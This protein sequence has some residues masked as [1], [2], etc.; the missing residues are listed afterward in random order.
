M[1]QPRR[2]DVL[3]KDAVWAATYGAAFTRQ[4]FDRL[5]EGRGAPNDDDFDRF[6]EEAASVA[7]EAAFRVN[8]KPK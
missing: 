7:D 2:K 6:H 4:V 8:E 3:M 5:Q 1:R